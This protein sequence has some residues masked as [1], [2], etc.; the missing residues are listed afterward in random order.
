MKKVDAHLIDE[1]HDQFKQLDLTNDG[2]VTKKDL[3]L[4][5]ARKL[6]KVSYKLQLSDY[7][8]KLRKQQSRRSVMHS[9]LHLM[10]SSRRLSV[11]KCSSA[12]TQS[13]DTSM[14]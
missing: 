4:I 13:N 2:L 12:D 10:A 3:Q 5:A 1:L 14:T 9:A 8:Q 11:P 7:K 6:R